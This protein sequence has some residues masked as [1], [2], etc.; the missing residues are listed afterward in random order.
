MIYETTRVHIHIGTQISV[1]DET[2]VW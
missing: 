2:A 1:L